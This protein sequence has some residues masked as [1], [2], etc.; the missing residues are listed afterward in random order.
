M[1]A[2][3]SHGAMRAMGIDS[4]MLAI[5]TGDH[6]PGLIQIP[7]PV[8]EKASHAAAFRELFVAGNRT[9]VSNTYFGA[10][11]ASV[12]VAQHAAVQNADIIHLHWVSGML[13]PPVIA[14]L[15]SAGR[16]VVCTLHDMAPFTGGCHYSAHCTAFQDDCRPCPQL[17]AFA[18]ALPAAQLADKR[19]LWRGG[20]LRVVA[21][22]AWMADLARR[23]P[24][25]RDREI[26]V[27]P[28]GIDLDQFN[29]TPRDKQR[30]EWGVAAETTVFLFVADQLGEQRKGALVLAESLN[31]L[32]GSARVKR[33]VAERRLVFLAAGQGKFPET[34]LPVKNLGWCDEGRMAASYAG[35]D[36]FLLPSVEDNL[37]NTVIESLAAGTPVIAF[38]AGGVPEMIQDGKT[39]RLVRAGDAAS[40]ANA[41]EDVLDDRTAMAAMRPQCRA[42]AEAHYDLTRNTKVLLDYYQPATTPAPRAQPGLAGDFPGPALNEFLNAPRSEILGLTP[43]E[44]LDRVIRLADRTQLEHHAVV[45]RTQR[46]YIS[47]LENE[48]KRLTAHNA[49][50]ERDHA[51]YGKVVKEQTE[52][53]RILETERDRLAAHHVALE[54]DIAHYV[55]VI[56]DQ[57]AYIKLL[58]EE[59]ARLRQPSS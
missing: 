11:L 51:H 44:F 20:H 24:V 39:G 41:I 49:A 4:T 31:R 3:R 8:G 45:T 36:L 32:A 12:D 55:K 53:V 35:A 48:G 34:A 54:R 22:T 52:H 25:L 57:T 16:N 10:E 18:D 21:L 59:R 17:R 46:E 37:P 9:P 56:N 47:G 14:Q 1:A 2:W 38:A 58:E 40:L 23:A 30:A 19:S 28:N 5:D 7:T 26:A 13:G 6:A 33:A 27:I 50:L 29:P 42:H 43:S 15:L